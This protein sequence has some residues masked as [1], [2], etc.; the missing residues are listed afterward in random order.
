M[1]QVKLPASATDEQLQQTMKSFEQYLS[2]QKEVGHYITLT[3][4][5]GD[6]ATGNAF[7]T[8]KDWS[9]RGG[10]GQDAASLSR[11]F[12]MEMA[13]RTSNANVFVMLPP[14]VRGLGSNAGFDVQLQDL[15]GIGHDALAQARDQ[16][17][18]L[19]K[20]DPALS[21]V[22]SNNL[23]D[24]PQ[25]AIDID[26]RKAARAGPDDLGHQR[27]AVQ[28]HGRQLRERLHQQR[29]REEG[30]RTSR[31]ALPHAARQRRPAGT[32]ATPAARWCRSRPSPP[33]RWT[34]GSPQ[35]S[36]YNGMSSFELIGDA[37]AGVSSGAAMDCGRKHHEA[38]AAGHR[39][40]VDRQL[41]PGAPVG[42]TGAAALRGV[43]S[44]RV[45]V[46]RPRCTRA[47]RCRS[48]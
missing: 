6:Q 33:A 34:Y 10:D 8:L 22:R 9:E 18:A 11:R 23:D 39:L 36:R 31:R 14:A 13:A 32:C 45:P 47:G 38:A 5:S 44:V 17:L 28:R 35:L 24:T 29:P 3:G 46:P 7:I 42:R 26:D 20:N 16:F 43:D 41:V 2:S 25:F 12:T 1:A 48:R 40:R 30:L 37:A 27:H 21:Q 4:L 15:G 19:A